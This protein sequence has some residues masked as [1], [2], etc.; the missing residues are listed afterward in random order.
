MLLC[1]MMDTV[2]CGYES[3]ELLQPLAAHGVGCVVEMLQHLKLC[4]PFDRRSFQKA[5]IYGDSG[6]SDSES[7]TSEDSKFIQCNEVDNG[8]VILQTE[9]EGLATKRRKMQ[10]NMH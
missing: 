8:N 9:K 1:G 2:E 6:E 5:G 4:H 3:M 7:C 10:L